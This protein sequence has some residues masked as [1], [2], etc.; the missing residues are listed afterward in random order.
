MAIHSYRSVGTEFQVMALATLRKAAIRDYLWY[1]S[2]W[3]TDFP[4]MSLRLL[5][6]PILFTDFGVRFK[7]AKLRRNGSR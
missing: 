5:D 1:R 6:A 3:R 7:L 2:P 4:L